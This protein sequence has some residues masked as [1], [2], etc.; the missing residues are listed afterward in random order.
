MM[1][2]F[3]S[4]FL[5][6]LF[7]KFERITANLRTATTNI[8]QSLNDIVN[9][10]CPFS[11][12]SFNR[13]NMPKKHFKKL[14]TMQGKVSL[15]KVDF[16]QGCVKDYHQQK[17]QVLTN[18]IS[19]ILVRKISMVYLNVQLAENLGGV[20]RMDTGCGGVKMESQ[21]AV[22]KCQL[23][24]MFISTSNLNRQD[25]GLMHDSEIPR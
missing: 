10:V 16:C 17:R 22:C 13:N 15:K 2:V 23:L 19:R 8:K 25:G 20:Q 4:H 18:H 21:H 14:Q 12:K 7:A 5:C 3:F 9:F 24:L 11:F 6:S 1:I